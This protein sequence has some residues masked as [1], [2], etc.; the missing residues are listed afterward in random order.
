MRAT[1]KMRDRE[2]AREAA[3]AAKQALEENKKAKSS[4]K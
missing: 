1:G 3:A 2:K 4:K